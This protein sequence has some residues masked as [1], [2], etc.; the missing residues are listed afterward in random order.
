[1]TCGTGDDRKTCNGKDAQEARI[2]K[3]NPA[4]ENMGPKLKIGNEE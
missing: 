1:M 4:M 2:W 3:L